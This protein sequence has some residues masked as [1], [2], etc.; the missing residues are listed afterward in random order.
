M[1]PKGDVSWLQSRSLTS[2]I[3]LFLFQWR[4]SWWQ[5]TRIHEQLPSSHV[6]VTLV[7]E[8][9]AAQPWMEQKAHLAGEQFSPGSLV[10]RGFGEQEHV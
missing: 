3:H 4:S 2:F 1:L 10:E 5:L 6:S 8:G 7:Q 9:L